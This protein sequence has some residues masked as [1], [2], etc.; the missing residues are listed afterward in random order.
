MKRTL[1]ILLVCFNYLA[2]SA[3]DEHFSQF[4]AMP[5]QMNPALAGAYE[6]TYRMS[7]IYRD[8]WSNNL[9]SPYKT[10]A[11]GGDTRFKVDFGNK[12]FK[13]HFGVGLYF[14]SDRVAEF[15]S[16]SNQVAGYFAYHKK[17][18][19]RVPS[20][21]GAGIKLGVIQRNINYDNLTFQD[22]FN[23][24]N[25]FEGFTSETLPPNNLGFF[26]TSFGLNYF[27]NADKTRYYAG[28]AIHHLTNPNISFFSR[29]DNPNPNLDLSETLDSRYVFHL[30]MDTE[31]QYRL[32][33]QPRVIYQSQGNDNQLD[34]GTNIK[35]TFESLNSG[36]VLGMW[37][38]AINDLDG[39]HLENITPLLGLIQGNFIFGF[40]YDIHLRD[41]F[42]T[43]FGFN[44][45]EFSI[46]FSGEHVNDANFCPTF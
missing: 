25:A 26:D 11:A 10:I 27:V 13:D 38:T 42:N 6:G 22:Q 28:F 23:Q 21:L 36:L 19:D 45:F 32:E 5:I 39:T 46:R 12:N 9:D 16:F 8:Q 33:L 34:I 3:Q 18:T 20:Y 15:Q 17:L 31:I 30:S 29:I 41:T 1:L 7:L 40:S 43:P 35:Y 2:L 24:I 44:T 14:T 37:V 4:Y